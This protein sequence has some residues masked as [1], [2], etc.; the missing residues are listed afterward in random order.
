MSTQRLG[1]TENVASKCV[2]V[3]A[4]AGSIATLTLPA[5]GTGL[6][7]YI[8]KIVITKLAAA[9]LTAAAVP[10]I[11]TTT[12]LT[13]T[14]AFDC[15]ADA[16]AQGTVERQNHDFAQ[17]LEAAAD[18]AAVTVVGPATTNVLWRITAFYFEK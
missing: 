17:A 8:T 14:P 6:R 1:P 15:A 9:L 11:V 4:A 18:A 7:I 16:A 13:G 3:T 12:G 10:V 5:P 2:T